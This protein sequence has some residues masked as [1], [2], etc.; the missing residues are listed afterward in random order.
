MRVSAEGYFDS[1][2]GQTYG[3]TYAVELDSDA[4]AEQVDELLSLDPH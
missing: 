4:H 1:T 2:T 3:I